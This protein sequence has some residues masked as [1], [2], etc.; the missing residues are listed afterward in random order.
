MEFFRFVDRAF[1]PYQVVSFPDVGFDYLSR[2]QPPP[3]YPY[4]EF[5]TNLT[6]LVQSLA[7]SRVEIAVRQYIINFLIHRI[8]DA[9][10]EQFSQNFV[11]LPC[12][13]CISGTFL[14]EADIDLVLYQYPVPCNPSEIMELLEATFGDVVIPG[15]W[16]PLAQAKVPVLKF[17]VDP[18][19]QIDLT[20]DELHGPLGIP[21]VRQIFQSFPILLPTQLFLKC[22]L[23]KQKLDQP[24]TGGISSYTLQFMCLAY[25]QYK[26]Q[27]ECLADFICGLCNFYGNE[28]NFTLTGIDVKGNG[29]FFSRLKEGKMY[30][31]SP[32]TMCIIDPLNPTNVLGHNSFKMGAIKQVFRETHEMITT[33]KVKELFEQFDGVRA[34]FQAKRQA[35]AEYARERNLTGE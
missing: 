14:P 16:Q 26:G 11:I 8:K 21:T 34:E 12:G 7:A 19:I 22:L 9:L 25:L 29:R 35:I 15:T 2:Q 24:Y 32:T 3:D 6:E 1:Q 33:G 18:G 28:F 4:T 23:Y 17:A 5:T 27:P 10:A 13:S 20:I 30:L 31:E